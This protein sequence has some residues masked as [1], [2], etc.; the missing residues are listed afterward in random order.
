MLNKKTLIIAE[1]GV[2]HNGDI[3]IAKKLIDAAVFAGADII[4]FQ[5]FLSK[6]LVTSTAKKSNYQ[7]KNSTT[8]ESQQEMLTKLE[9]TKSDHINLIKYCKYKEIEFLSSAFDMESIKFLDSLKLK[10]WKIPSGEITNYP[11]LRLIGSKN[12]PIILSTGMSTI[13]E[14]GNA[15]NILENS[16]CSRDKITIL[17]CN[18]EYP[19]PFCDVNLKV[20]KS[21]KDKFGLKTGF[22]DHTLGIESSI[23][24]VALGATIIEKHLTLDKKMNGPDHKASLEPEDFRNLVLSIR[25]IEKALGDGKKIVTDSEAKN[26]PLVRK[27]IFAKRFIKKGEK[28]SESNICLKRPES[29]IP[30]IYWDKVLKLYAIKDFEFDEE[31]VI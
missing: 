22:S 14:I 3:D 9:L 4:K 29:G 23:A 1:A 6:N 27:S 10:R 19:T 5:T 20:I 11:Y 17:Q 31:I 30:A 18:T 2:N 12:I 24:A 28:L 13:K 7:E 8:E 16:G 25:N 21:L 26:K 15:I